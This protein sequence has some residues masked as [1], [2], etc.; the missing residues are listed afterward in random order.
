[1]IKSV[2]HRC[3]LCLRLVS[4]ARL[5]G[6]ATVPEQKVSPEEQQQTISTPQPHDHYDFVGPPNP[7]SNIREV[8]YSKAT[9]PEEE[10]LNVKRSMTYHWNDQFWTRHNNNFFTEKKKFIEQSNAASGSGQEVSD[11]LSIFYKDFL[12]KNHDTYME[13]NREWYRQNFTL[14]WMNARAALLKPFSSKNKAA[15]NTIEQ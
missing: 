10:V 4:P 1:M 11:K 9:H 15:T 12:E 6:T 14:L 8:I 7:E 2:L 3:P 5:F 13:Y